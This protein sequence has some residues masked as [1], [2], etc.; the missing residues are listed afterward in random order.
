MNYILPSFSQG[1]LLTDSCDRPWIAENFLQE[2]QP[3]S[4]WH[5]P[6]SSD[7]VVTKILFTEAIYIKTMQDFL[8]TWGFF[9]TKCLC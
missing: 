7:T 5:K 3:F 9:C 1:M 2:I 8:L 4:G 6:I